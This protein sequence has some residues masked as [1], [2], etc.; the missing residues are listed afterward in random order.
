MR[1]TRDPLPL[2]GRV[3]SNPTP[4]AK[5]LVEQW[6]NSVLPSGGAGGGI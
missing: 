4:G 5:F 6:S 2:R 1:R 3:G